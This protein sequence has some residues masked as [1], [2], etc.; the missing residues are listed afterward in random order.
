VQQGQPVLVLRE[1]EQTAV[2][3]LD[4]LDPVIGAAQLRLCALLGAG[5]RQSGGGTENPAQETA[6][7]CLRVEKA[8]TNGLRRSWS[9]RRHCQVVC[10][11]PEPTRAGKFCCDAQDRFFSTM[12]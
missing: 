12:W 3:A 10:D 7:V 4:V 11:S 5:G 6:T 8:C 1:V 2:G 9:R